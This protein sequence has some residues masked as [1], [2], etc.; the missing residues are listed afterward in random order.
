[1]LISHPSRRKRT[2]T[3]RITALAWQAPVGQGIAVPDA[4][5]ANLPDAGF[6]AGLLAA[7]GFVMIRGP[8]ELQDAA[9]PP[10]RHAPFIAN[11]ARQL[12]LARRPHIFRR[13]TS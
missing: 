12:A 6:D 2:W 8:V 11:H 4:R 1:M 10:D 5:L 9:R 3:R 13:M 7:A